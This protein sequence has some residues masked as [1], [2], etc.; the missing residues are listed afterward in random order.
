LKPIGDTFVN[1]VKMVI[2]PVV[3][4]TIVL[5][6]A[7]TLASTQSN[8]AVKT[9]ALAGRASVRAWLGNWTDAAQVPA[10]FVFNA[11]FSTNTPRED[12]DLANQTITRRETTV[13]GTVYAGTRSDPRTTWD[14]VKTTAG[15]V[16]TGQDGKTPFFRQTKYTSLGSPVPLAKG[17][18]M[19]LLRA[20]ALLDGGDVGGAM[21]LINQER[22]VYSLPA[23][24]AGDVAA[25]TTVLHAERGS[26]LWLEGRRLWDLR[27]WLAAGSDAFLSDRAKCIPASANEMAANPLK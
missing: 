8:T 10:S 9:A 2:A 13:Y 3:F 26:V 7:F 19:L 23:L 20:E 14:T 15:K 25:A 24:T 21:T 6:I 27:R 5:G 12:N 16:Q 22:A 17:T 1:L 11:I 18:E 4:L